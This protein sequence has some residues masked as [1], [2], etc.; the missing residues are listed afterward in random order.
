M[1]TYEILYLNYSVVHVCVLTFRPTAIG[2]SSRTGTHV[3]R[4]SFAVLFGRAPN[5]SRVPV[6][7]RTC[8]G[9]LLRKRLGDPNTY[10]SFVR[11]YFF[12]IDSGDNIV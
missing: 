12:E 3:S 1:H 4:E 7:V 11:Q 2:R 10:C 6:H 5:T 9:A 8:I